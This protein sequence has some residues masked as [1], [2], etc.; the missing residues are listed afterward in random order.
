MV[1]FLQ[2][3][4]N[5][6]SEM[7]STMQQGRQEGAVSKEMVKEVLVEVRGKRV[8]PSSGHDI[9]AAIP[10]GEGGAERGQ[11]EAGPQPEGHHR[12]T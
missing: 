12:L 2:G 11:A 9:I 10:G 5:R 6:L 8:S 7:V 1:T 4:I 3:Q